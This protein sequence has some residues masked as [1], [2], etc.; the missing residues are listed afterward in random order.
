SD[1]MIKK[2]MSYFED[3]GSLNEKQEVFYYA[4]SV[5]RDLQDT[6]RALEYFLKSLDYVMQGNE[7]V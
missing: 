5:Y 4:G 6:P 7:W 1:L 3:K 2:L